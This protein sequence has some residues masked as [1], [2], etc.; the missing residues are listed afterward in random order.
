MF[1]VGLK[2]EGVEIFLSKEKG[3]EYIEP[4]I[5]FLHYIKK[6]LH[7]RSFFFMYSL[8]MFQKL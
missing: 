6:M 1:K 8:S 3:K 2:I 4:L 5:N 7:Q